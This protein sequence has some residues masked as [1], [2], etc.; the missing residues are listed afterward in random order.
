MTFTAPERK[1]GEPPRLI[2]VSNRLPVTIKKDAKTGEYTYKVGLSSSSSLCL[3]E[4]LNE[5]RS[6]MLLFP[7]YFLVRRC[8]I[9]SIFVPPFITWIHVLDLDTSTLD[10]LLSTVDRNMKTPLVDVLRRSRLGALG[11]QEDDAIHLDRL[12]RPRRQC[13]LPYLGRDKHI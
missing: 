7:Y 2:V 13:P 12:A 9:H 5:S 1:E 10:S 11:M 3:R 8:C 6:L 4:V